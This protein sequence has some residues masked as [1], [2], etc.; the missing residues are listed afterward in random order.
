MRLAGASGCLFRLIRFFRRPESYAEKIDMTFANTPHP[1]RSSAERMRR[2]RA[3]RRRETQFLAFELDKVLIDA[4]VKH[5]V[6]P[7]QARRDP[8]AIVAAIFRLLQVALF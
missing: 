4:M 1:H 3:R 8:D 7:Y 5:G 6:L 2:H